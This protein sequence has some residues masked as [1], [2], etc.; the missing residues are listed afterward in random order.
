MRA[1][2]PRRASGLAALAVVAAMA[3]VAVVGSATMAG[4]RW[5]EQPS[6]DASGKV[7]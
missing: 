3:V 4:R 2:L 7:V 1:A 5:R 6:R